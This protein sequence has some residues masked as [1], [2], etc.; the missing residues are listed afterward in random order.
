MRHSARRNL[1]SQF[2]TQ[3][4]EGRETDISLIPWQSHRSL[5]S[6]MF[7]LINNPTE[8]DFKEWVHAAELE[9]WR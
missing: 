9:T 2:F 7:N 3:E 1:G 8:E 4:Y 5:I 6:A